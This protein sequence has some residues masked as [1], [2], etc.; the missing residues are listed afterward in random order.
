[1]VK[2]ETI[3]LEGEKVKF[4][5]GALRKQLKLKPTQKLSKA[6]LNKVKKT[7]VGKTFE[8]FKKKHKMTKLMKKRIN[9]AIVLMGRKKK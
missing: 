3:E 8:L 1:M 4:K 9:F 2:Y 7:E 5:E 6:M